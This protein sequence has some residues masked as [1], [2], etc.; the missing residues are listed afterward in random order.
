[1]RRL[2]KNGRG[3]PEPNHKGRRD[4]LHCLL[5]FWMSYTDAVGSASSFA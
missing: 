4:S 1:L 3:Q 2:W 5:A